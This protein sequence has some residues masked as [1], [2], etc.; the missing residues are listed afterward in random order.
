MQEP[1]YI[2]DTL[3]H[4]TGRNKPDEEAF[5]ILK[6]ICLMQ[7]LRLSYCP[8]YQNIESI[9]MTCFTDIP[10][11][12]S[13]EHCKLFGKFGI[14]F[15]KSNMIKYGSNP[16]LYT[17]KK[18]QNIIQSAHTLLSKMLE[19]D[20]DREWKEASQEYFFTIDELFAMQN[21]FSFLQEYSHNS[22]NEDN[23]V[24]YYQR[25]WRLALKTL[26]VPS[27]SD[28]PPSGQAGSE[29]DDLDK[30]K[31]H[32]YFKFSIEDVAYIIVPE[33][34]LSSANEISKVLKNCEIKIYEKVVTA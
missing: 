16:V 5:K 13:N 29:L 27:G 18:Y 22:T 19:L 25:E 31:S 9:L 8:P 23:N 33:N 1:K 2:N 20:K 4:W 15:H 12:F 34:Y 14:G 24:N 21:V 7:R 28:E 6:R 17:T 30:T 10:L 3:V 11:N 26:P 32:W